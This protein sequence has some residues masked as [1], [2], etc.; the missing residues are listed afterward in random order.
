MS[1]KSKCD[2][3]GKYK[4]SDSTKKYKSSREAAIIVMTNDNDLASVGSGGVY[5]GKGITSSGKFSVSS[6]GSLIKFKYPG[7]YRLQFEGMIESEG[8]EISLVFKRFPSFEENKLPFSQFTCSRGEV[9]KTTILP[10][11]YGDKLQIIMRSDNGS[12]VL[13]AKHTRLLVIRVDDL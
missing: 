9:S 11:N 7:L 4:D 12:P 8:E 1:K 13:V 3:C 6:D 10:F 5:F 2:K